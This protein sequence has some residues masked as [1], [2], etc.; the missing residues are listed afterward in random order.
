[1]IKYSNIRIDIAPKWT[2]YQQTNRYILPLFSLWFDGKKYKTVGFMV[3]WWKWC[4]CVFFT[5]NN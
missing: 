1:M 5:T 2:E 3:G 4:I